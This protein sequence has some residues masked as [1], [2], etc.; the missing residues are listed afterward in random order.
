MKAFLLFFLIFWG[1]SHACLP[2]FPLKDGWLGGDAVYSI[3]LSK[4]KNLWLFGDT[5]IGENRRE[6]AFISNSIAISDCNGLNWDIKYIWK[7]Y[8]NGPEAFFKDREQGYR[9]WP[10]DGFIHN[11]VLNI[12]FTRVRTIA[13]PI[14]LNFEVFD[15]VLVQ[16]LNP[17]ESP[18]NWR[19]NQKDFMKG[20][21]LIGGTSVLK[22]GKYLYQ[23]A[24]GRDVNGSSPLALI[25]SRLDNVWINLEIL[26]N[27]MWLK[28]SPNSNRD[29][30]FLISKGAQEVSLSWNPRLKIYEMIIPGN[31]LSGGA[32]LWTASRL[33]GKWEN[34][35][36]IFLYPELVQ[37]IPGVFCYAAKYHP[38]FEVYTYACNS[39]DESTLL[40]N[41]KIYRPI[42]L[43][44]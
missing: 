23:F 38:R 31:I 6:A 25:R 40:D 7:D 4:T 35:G 28:Y 44:K 33:D 3:P 1:K 27:G 32:Y 10:K 41:L 26:D 9:L 42:V 37:S 22:K 14:G 30:H 43:P 20:V 5:F 2:S 34:K 19:S 8:G 39:F 17:L 36:Q 21:E 29:G 11:G 13:G 24:S 12:F 15:T 18:H 16:V